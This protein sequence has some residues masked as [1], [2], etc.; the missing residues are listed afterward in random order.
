MV[1]PQ[2]INLR[3]KELQNIFEQEIQPHEDIS[4][5]RQ[6]DYNKMVESLNEESLRDK[7]SLY[8]TRLKKG[9]E[10][11]RVNLKKAKR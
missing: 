1:T 4:S 2:A 9:V 10:K 7:H 6:R 5:I 8:I 3:Y 11:E